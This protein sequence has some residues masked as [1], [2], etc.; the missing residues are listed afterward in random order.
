MSSEYLHDVAVEG[1]RRRRRHQC[2][3]EDRRRVPAST[4][5]YLLYSYKSTNTDSISVALRIAGVYLPARESE[6]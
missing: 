5:V 4:L 1:L 6:V 2:R 3:L